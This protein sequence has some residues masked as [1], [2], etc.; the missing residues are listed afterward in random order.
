MSFVFAILLLLSCGEDIECVGGDDTVYVK[1]P[2]T[3]TKQVI[4]VDE[5]CKNGVYHSY[6]SED[7]LMIRCKCA[8]K[9]K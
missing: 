6:V 7:T 8:T 9:N 1:L 3:D 4:R 2:C 5:Y